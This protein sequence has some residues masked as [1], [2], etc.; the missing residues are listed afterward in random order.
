MDQS[1]RLARKK[2]APAP[3]SGICIPNLVVLK[4]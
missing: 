4:V 3:R 1:F 2:F